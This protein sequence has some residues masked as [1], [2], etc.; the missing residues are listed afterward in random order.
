VSRRSAPELLVLHAVRLRGMA[1]HQGVARRFGLDLDVTEETLLDHQAV[2]WVTWSQ[3]AGTGGWS[4]TSAGRTEDERQLAAELAA[5]GDTGADTIRRAYTEF[6]PWNDRLQR[7]CTD[8]QLRPDGDEPLAENDHT[9]PAW[10]ARVLADL[11]AID[12]ALR[13]LVSRLSG[14]LDRFRGYDV[15]FSTAL[16]RAAAGDG[17]WVNRVG[18]D[19]CHTVWME[20]HEDL[21]ATLGMPRG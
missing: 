7:A 1:G 3:F 5:V 9:D 17:S 19:S 6:L 14:V 4:L 8:W 10:D 11:A 20:L 12:G 18:A 2:G 13:P 16:R 15:R 21:L